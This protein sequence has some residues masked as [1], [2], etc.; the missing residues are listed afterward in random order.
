M[1]PYLLADDLSGALEAGAAFRAQGTPVT[2]S[3][4]ASAPPVAA[5]VRILSSETRNVPPAEAARVLAALLTAQRARGSQLLLKKIDSTLRGPIAAEIQALRKELSPPLVVFCPAN[6]AVGRTVREGRL[7]VHGVPVTET[8]FGNDPGW[9][10]KESHLVTLLETGGVR[11]IV[12]LPLAALRTAGALPSTH[13]RGVLV[14]DAETREDLAQLVRLVRQAEPGAVFVGSGGLAHALA[15]GRG[16]PQPTEW[17]VPRSVLIVCGSVN[18]RSRR[19]LEF[20][21]D[22][23]AVPMHE[24]VSAPGG[25]GDLIAALTRSLS[26]RGVA[27]LT[28]ARE[29][30]SADPA[31][32]VRRL[33]AEVVK[34]ALAGAEPEMLAMT[35]GETAQA[36]CV[37]LGIEQLSLVGEIEPGVVVA[38]ITG[39]GPRKLTGMIIKPGGFG[40]DNIWSNIIPNGR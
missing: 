18:A 30:L 23:H 7:F 15:A 19:Q 27:V 36:V 8:D 29:F 5:G 26:Q 37:A 34:L 35:G 1:N 12:E 3:L 2:L 17:Q 33:A 32:P 40:S 10:V 16:S 25:A 20:L 4:A 9:P 39:G 28:V 6:P 21:R 24:L 31:T 22:Q 13:R 38:R 14:S 11:E